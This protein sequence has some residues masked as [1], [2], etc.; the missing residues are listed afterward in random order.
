M[1]QGGSNWSI[2]SKFQNTHTPVDDSAKMAEYETPGLRFP[3]QTII[4]LAES[5]QCNYSGTLGSTKGL[6]PSRKAWKINCG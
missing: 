3:T 1:S 6:Q 2:S 5:A 4:A